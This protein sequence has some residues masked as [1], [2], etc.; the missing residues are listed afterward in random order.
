M[1]AMSSES[2]RTL[3][4][5]RGPLIRAETADCELARARKLLAEHGSIGNLVRLARAKLDLAV[6]PT[7]CAID[8][9]LGDL[10][11]RQARRLLRAVQV[12]LD[13]ERW[14][15]RRPWW[16]RLWARVWRLWL[17]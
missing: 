1:P 11:V 17:W 13:E 6:P 4:I 2:L 15:A 5:P 14:Q 7:G 3:D 8:H 12:L 9:R 10:Q 16:A